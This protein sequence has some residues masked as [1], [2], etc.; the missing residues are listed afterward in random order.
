MG[1]LNTGGRITDIAIH[2]SNTDIIYA[3]A[4]SGGIFKST[5][6]GDS[7]EPIFDNAL[8]LSIGDLD[9]AT[10]D[11]NTIYVG[12]GESNA[13]GGSLAYDGVGIYKTNDG[14][15]NWTH[16]G[17]T[18]IGSVGKVAVDP[19][20]PNRAF[21]AAMGDLFGNNPERGVFRT[22]DGGAS[23][24]Q[25]LHVTDSTGAV[26]LAI[27]P[28]QPDTIYAALWQRVRQPHRRS[29]G[30]PTSGIYRSFDGGTTWTP[31]TS[32]LPSQDKGRIGLSIS[33]SHPNQVFASITDIAGLLINVYK[34]TNNGDT[35]APIGKAGTSPTPYMWWFGRIFV[36]PKNPDTIF[37]SNLDVERTANGG[38]FWTGI[39]ANVHV[40]Q[41][42]M[43]ID[44]NNPDFIVIGNDGGVYITYNGGLNWAHKN[45]LPITQFYTCEI[46]NF[47][48]ERLYG[49]TQDNGTIRTLTGNLDDWQRILGGDGFVCLVNPINHNYVYAESQYGGLAR[50]VNGGQTFTGAT[51]GI[52]F[53]DP[54]NWNMP[55]I[56]D[57]SDPSILYLGTD[58]VYKSTNRAESW[59]PISPDL[60]DAPPNTNIVFGTLTTLAASAVN[61]DIIYAGSDDGKVWNTT[62]G[63]A[64]WN[65]LSDNLPNRWVTRVATDPIDVN[66]AYVTFSGYRYYEYLP[67][68]FKTEDNGTTWID[69][70]GDLPE[71]P[72]N[73]ILINPDDNNKLYLATDV[74]VFISYN[75]GD[76]WETLGQDLPNVPVT[77]LCGYW[78]GQFIIAAT[79]GRSMHKID[80]LE[81]DID[82]PEIPDFTAKAFPNPFI[83]QV[84]ISLDLEQDAQVEINI[85]HSNGQLVKKQFA[86]NLSGGQHH[87]KFR[88]PSLPAGIYICQILVDGRKENLIL[89]KL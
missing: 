82:Q 3:G 53:G 69:I 74:G 38:Q 27:H 13:G 23:W 1:P 72:V 40:D 68:V 9:I 66:T 31:L 39:S 49:G 32:G 55:V 10:S 86:G 28:T 36:H 77:D 47:E 56:F 67:H 84:N 85:Y 16:L 21:V 75:G 88:N 45:T 26:D 60:T 71:V 2:P 62:N 89:N 65:L 79:Y 46:D 18:D 19:Q 34:S 64:N 50:S 20:N 15:Q 25:V 78:S 87:F 70:S 22:Q 81:T 14:G 76:N 12:T 73:D 80:I 33:P 83:D 4:A 48:P 42:S 5:D 35:W 41:H 17:L 7:W 43:Y 58:K 61:T 30:G 52:G 54:K 11:P 24:E 57:P 6:Q 44:P 59:F 8:S 37:L 51:T 29:Y 63:G